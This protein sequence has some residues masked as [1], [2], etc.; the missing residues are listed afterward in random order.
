LV[1]VLAPRDGSLAGRSAAFADGDTVVVRRAG[2]RLGDWIVRS[3][4]VDGVTVVHAARATT[5]QL[6]I[7]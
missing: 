1:A 3:I 4:D 5:V 6:T 2:E 7:R